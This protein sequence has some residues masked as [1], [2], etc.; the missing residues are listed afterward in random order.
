MSESS[1]Q[2]ALFSLLNTLAGCDASGRPIVGST[3]RLPLLRW[4]FHVPNG[5]KRDKATAARLQSMGVRRGIP[6]IL[7]PV[8]N[9]Q[10][11]D[12]KPV[13]FFVGLAIELKSANGRTRPAQREWLAQLEVYGWK[14][15]VCYEW[16]DAARLLITW[17]GGDPKEI[18]GL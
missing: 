3:P 1:D 16:R 12:G 14:S 10:T 7:F 11:I 9:Q 18:E 13:C 8:L 6:D 4:C 5:E 17:A 15:V 2:A